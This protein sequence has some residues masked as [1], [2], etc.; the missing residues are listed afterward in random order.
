VRESPAHWTTRPGTSATPGCLLPRRTKHAARARPE[1]A[2]L[3]G[4]DSAV[5]AWAGQ[6][7][8]R[9]VIRQPDVKPPIGARRP[10]RGLCRR[11][12]RAGWSAGNASLRCGIAGRL[13]A[14]HMPRLGEEPPWVSAGCGR[15]CSSGSSRGSA[16][17][18]R[19]RTRCLVERPWR[20]AAAGG[21]LMVD[22]VRR[23]GRAD[24]HAEPAERA[25]VMGMRTRVAAGPATSAR[26][27]SDPLTSPSLSRTQPGR[28]REL[29]SPEPRSRSRRPGRPAAGDPGP[30]R[31]VS[32]ASPA[33]PRS[34]A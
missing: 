8:G 30:G 10:S 9:S 15:R 16:R 7:P 14:A 25:D 28:A 11:F 19:R 20:G 33:R 6:H 22:R 32:R 3:H 17:R 1:P 21:P 13:A 2:W 26:A 24:R 34:P 23:A 12:A 5:S 4:A 27:Y 18:G 31:P 29:G